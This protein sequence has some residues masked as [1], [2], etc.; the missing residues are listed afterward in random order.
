MLRLGEGFLEGVLQWGFRGK[1]GSEND[2]EKGLRRGLSRGHLP[3]S[4][5]PFGESTTPSPSR[6]RV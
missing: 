3:A 5:T 4:N 1:K 6:S 2:P